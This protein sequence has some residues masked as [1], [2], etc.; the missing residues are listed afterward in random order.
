VPVPFLVQLAIGVALNILAYML[1]P[2]PKEPKPPALQDFDAPTAEAGRPIPV[3]WGNLT[4]TGLNV[5]GVFDKK[6]RKRKV[7][8]GKK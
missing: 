1:A 8:V 7:E 6:I 2:K 4:I 3:I 5:I